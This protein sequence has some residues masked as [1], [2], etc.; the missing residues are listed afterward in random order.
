MEVSD[1]YSNVLLVLSYLTHFFKP[2]AEEFA[3]KI[4]LDLW[5]K[6][7]TIGTKIKNHI[8]KKENK[9]LKKLY[10]SFENN[11]KR[12][13]NQLKKEIEKLIP[14]DNELNLL[15]SELLSLLEKNPNVIQIA[16]G[17]KNII[18]YTDN[19]STSKIIINE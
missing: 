9:S 12:Y 5:E 16:Y 17:D 2:L 14:Q 6:I 11:P 1:A 4:G 19:N 15:V 3:K 10:S 18:T 8:T 7:K 13:K